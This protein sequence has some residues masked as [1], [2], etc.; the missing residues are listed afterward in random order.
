MAFEENLNKI[1]VKPD[2]FYHACYHGHVEL[3]KQLLIHYKTY[4]Q[5]THTE[6]NSGFT[7]FHLACAGGQTAVVELLLKEYDNCNF[8]KNRDGLTGLEV[9][10]QLSQISVVNSILHSIGRQDMR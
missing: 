3:V 9:A 6:E 1:G 5:I 8:L 10:A 2:L 4:F 7:A